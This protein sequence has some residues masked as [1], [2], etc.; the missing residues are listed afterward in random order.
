MRIKLPNFEF[1]NLVMAGLGGVG[2]RI[3]LSRLTAAK[4]KAR[5]Q[6]KD[7]SISKEMLYHSVEVRCKIFKPYFTEFESPHQRRK[8]T[9]CFLSGSHTH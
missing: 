8:G 9:Y 7:L 4:G 1:T 6:I 3:G 5:R 2:S